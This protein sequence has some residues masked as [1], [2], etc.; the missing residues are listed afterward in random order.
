MEVTAKSIADKCDIGFVMS[1]VNPKNLQGLLAV[2]RGAV[3]SHILDAKYVTDSSYFPTHVLDIY[4][5]RRGQY[6]NVRIWIQLD[7]GT[8]Q[9][10]DLFVTTAN[11]EPIQVDTIMSNM[12]LEIK[13]W[14]NQIGI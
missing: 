11:N 8:G 5:M 1:R 9:R 6:K 10:R 12:E 13:D 7:L 3:Q 2:W 4:K 14:R